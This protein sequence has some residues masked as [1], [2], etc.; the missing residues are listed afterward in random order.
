MSVLEVARLTVPEG[1]ADDF[2]MAFA[3]AH[4]LVTAAGGRLASDLTRIVGTTSDYLFVVEWRTLADHVEGFAGSPDF[5]T[6]EGLI[7]PYLVG[8]PVVH[9]YESIEG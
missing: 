5:A 7:G 2:E 9:H 8:A 4:A 1:A 3:E 6:F